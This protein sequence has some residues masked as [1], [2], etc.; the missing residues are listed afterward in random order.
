LIGDPRFDTAAA[1]LKHEPEVDA[2]IAAWTRQHDKREAMRVLGGAGV[3]ARAIFDTIDLTAQPDF[4]RRG[5][6]HTIEHPIA[7]PF[8]MPGWAV[9]FGGRTP[10]VKPSP[11]LGQHTSEVLSEWL[12]LDAD[13]IDQLGKDKII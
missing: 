1:R 2:M 5:I 11:L 8:K 12:G 13:Q 10:D 6:M 7:R 3:P 9:R 4:V